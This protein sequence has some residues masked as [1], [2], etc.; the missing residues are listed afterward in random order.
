MST[1][2]A[3]CVFDL[4]PDIL[5]LIED[6]LDVLLLFRTATRELKSPHFQRTLARITRQLP[7][8]TRDPPHPGRHLVRIIRPQYSRTLSTH[9]KADHYSNTP[10]DIHGLSF[11]TGQTSAW[12]GGRADIEHRYG[13]PLNCYTHNE[14][15]D[16]LEA[17]GYKRFKSRKKD[18]KIK[19]LMKSL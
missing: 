14:I 1:I 12:G 4:A 9:A 13:N 11:T 19:M 17:L 18:V 5:R 2:D 7:T 6:E 3:S 8:H 15:N 10:I 16:R